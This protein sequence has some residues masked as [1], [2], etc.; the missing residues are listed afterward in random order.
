MRRKRP[1]WSEASSSPCYK[2]SCW[3]VPPPPPQ[4][5][6]FHLKTHTSGFKSRSEPG[7]NVSSVCGSSWMRGA[8]MWKA[9]SSACAGSAKH[10]VA[11]AKL[12]S[13][14]ISPGLTA[15]KS[16]RGVAAFAEEKWEVQR[17]KPALQRTS[18]A[19]LWMRLL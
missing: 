1:P 10:K 5:E 3:P 15:Q 18:A 14:I 17:G 6:Q 11:S 2:P 7:P 8:R 12:C 19:R 13:E 9:L 16:S 4:A